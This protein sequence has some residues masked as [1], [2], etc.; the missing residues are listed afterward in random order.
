MD[1]LMGMAIATGIGGLIQGGL[2]LFQQKKGEEARQE[3]MANQPQF[4]TPAAINELTAMYGDYLSEVQGREEMPG[5]AQI[6]SNIRE[7]TAGGISSI[8]E[9]ARSST[10]A[11]G[12]TT[13]V[14]GQE[15]ESIQQLNVQAAQQKAR[16]ELQAM[17]M[18][19]GALQQQAQYEQQEFMY[20]EYMPWQT[21]LNEA[22][23]QVQGGWQN[24]SAG[25]S[26]MAQGAGMYAANQLG[27]SNG[28]VNTGQSNADWMNN[29]NIW[30][31][32]NFA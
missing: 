10:E 18:Y 26:G 30:A 11:L 27:G 17:Q 19:G 5:Q 24:I 2:G 7:S 4:Q 22:Q 6:E 31:G 8:R 1:P 3:A 32:G 14:I 21:R 15:I 13:D 9:T 12:A 25:V 16:Q 29:T 23:A 28:D 20:N